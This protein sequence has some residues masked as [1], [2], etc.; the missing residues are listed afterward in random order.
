MLN[1]LASIDPLFEKDK[2]FRVEFIPINNVYTYYQ[3]LV[4]VK[5]EGT[6]ADNGFLVQFYTEGGLNILSILYRI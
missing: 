3:W 5:D 1:W 2:I 6:I 4:L